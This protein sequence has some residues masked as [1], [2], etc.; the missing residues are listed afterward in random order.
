MKNTRQEWHGKIDVFLNQKYE[1]NETYSEII[2]SAITSGEWWDKVWSLLDIFNTKWLSK[3]NFSF[4][5]SNMFSKLEKQ[6][7]IILFDRNKAECTKE[8]IQYINTIINE[9][10]EYYN[11][12]LLRNVG[13]SFVKKWNKNKNSDKIELTNTK[14]VRDFFSHSGSQKNPSATRQIHCSLL[15]I[16]YAINDIKTNEEKIDKAEK[17]FWEIKQNMFFSHF[18]DYKGNNASEN[19]N[20]EE[21]DFR[22]IKLQTRCEKSLKWNI[23]FNCAGRVKRKEQIL[24]K[25]LS[26]PKYDSVEVIKDIYGIRN[27][28]KTK[29]EALLLLEYIRIH[30]L[31]KSGEISYKNIFGEWLEESQN[32][33]RENASKLDPD[34][35]AEIYKSLNE[36]I[37]KWKNNKDY[38]D[39]KIRGNLGWH[40]CEIQINLVDNK[41][42]TGY[43]HHLIF[44]CKKKIRALSRLQWYIP[45]SIIH[46]Y[47]REAI[48]KSILEAEKYWGNAELVSLWWYNWSMKK[49]TD[50]HKKNAENKIFNYLLNKE[51]DIVK[52]NIPGA[53]NNLNYYT[54]LSNRNYF[55]KE[56]KNLSIY[57]QWAKARKTKANERTDQAIGD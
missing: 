49:I 12:Y 34:F 18:L 14:E 6:T 51:Q 7:W 19:I 22:Y 2:F 32:F 46:R 9:A 43:A 3:H 33:V 15:K 45:Y 23:L 11:N 27:E 24:V 57:P 48:D 13:S 16:A 5:L 20:N 55:H 29:E 28:V 42:E 4:L 26:D 41:N 38:K 30:V 50:E 1:K 47:I 44:D 52:I 36:D 10:L 56:E 39:V 8:G 31:N 54:S 37:T 40:S 21:N 17:E 25:E 53:N 35:Y